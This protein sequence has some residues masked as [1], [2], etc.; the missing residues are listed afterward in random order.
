MG[1][2]YV[3]EQLST[4]KQR[5]LK[6]MHPQFVSDESLRERFT[7]E[8]R[9]G[10]RIESEHVVDVVAAGIDAATKMPWLAM[11]LLKGETVAEAVARGRSAQPH[12][13][14]ESLLQLGDVLAEAHHAGVVHRDLKPENLFLTTTKRTD[15][16][17]VL[18]VLDFGIAKL[19]SEGATSVTAAIGTPMWMAPE[20]TELGAAITPATDVWAL[21]LIAFFVLT[22][23][24]YWRLR[25]EGHEVSGAALLR[26]IVLDPLPLASERAAEHGFAAPLPPGFDAWFARCCAR[27]P[28]ARFSDGSAALSELR[29][30]FGCDA[31]PFSPTAPTEVGIVAM[32]AAHTPAPG[33][34]G[35]Q[36]LSSA[37]PRSTDVVSP[38]PSR[39]QGPSGLA[40][41]PVAKTDGGISDATPAPLAPATRRTGAVR[42][43]VVAFAA[44]AI[45]AGM[46]YAASLRRPADL[47]SSN[48]KERDAA[49]TSSGAS[50]AAAS[51]SARG[52]APHGR[53]NPV[54]P[55]DGAL[56]SSTPVELKWSHSGGPL[57]EHDIEVARGDV[58]GQRGHSPPG[59]TYAMWPW[60]G[61]MAR[62]GAYRWR[63][64]EAEDEWSAWATFSF[65]PSVLDR[66][67][68]QRRLRVGMET[69]YHE[70]FVY[71]D[72]QQK[73]VVGF[74]VD[75]A[76]DV[77]AK[78]GVALD[79]VSREWKDLFTGVETR[80]LDVVISAVSVTKDRARKYGFSE[81]YLRTGVVVT[82]RAATSRLSAPGKGKTVG[83]QRQTTAAETAKRSFSQATF[84]E[85]DTLDSAFAALARSEIDALLSDETVVLPRAEVKAGGYR[86]DSARLTDDAYGIMMP[87]G[88]D[89]LRARMNE[90]LKELIAA[91]RIAELKK[92]YGIR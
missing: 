40:G 24:S 58:A 12:F 30:V 48:E 92:T 14:K 21:G 32:H 91:G 61:E 31:A 69:T 51:A 4:G 90:I 73:K 50:T 59:V 89:R 35:T 76:N 44:V 33:P 57:H 26:Q 47:T 17:F 19:L 38:G 72:A 49:I 20:Q 55:R 77:A 16:P 23:H 87:Q 54:Q 7:Q 65:Y 11:E 68:D 46:A 63:V 25:S 71:Y 2:V 82:T 28:T 29:K 83:A 66:I 37:P 34:H 36:P 85:Y 86:I 1:A 45:I 53:S 42:G 56:L 18:K 27:Q 52:T 84:R 78:L 64:R 79:R 62:P 8:A 5:A 9:I 60:P 74:D 3:A 70:P 13:A 67:E 22:G 75:L 41:V 43:L 81:P 80:D 39:P 6:T 88:D 10:A 15:V